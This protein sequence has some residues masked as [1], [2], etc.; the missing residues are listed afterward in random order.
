MGEEIH[1]AND[2]HHTEEYIDF[3]SLWQMKSKK[4]CEKSS[5][6]KRIKKEK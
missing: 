4:N 6:K 3:L 2:K 5:F 1:K